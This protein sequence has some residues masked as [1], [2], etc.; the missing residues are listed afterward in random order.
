M[1]I[2]GTLLLGP[3]EHNADRCFNSFKLLGCDLVLV[4]VDFLDEKTTEI[5]NRA[6][7][8]LNIEVIHDKW[9]Y[10]FGRSRNVLQSK[11]PPGF[12]W[13]IWLDS[14]DEVTEADAAVFIESFSKY[15][16][17][18][19]LLMANYVYVD[20][21]GK[22]TY[23]LYRERAFSPYG[24]FWKLHAHEYPAMPYRRAIFIPASVIHHW[25]G[26]EPGRELRYI[27]GLLK[28]LNDPN[29]VGDRARILYY[30]ARS[31]YG[32]DELKEA[33]KYFIEY[34]NTGGW[35]EERAVA[36]LML[37]EIC[38]HHNDLIGAMKW[39][40]WASV[41]M[42]RARREMMYPL[43]EIY[44][45]LGVPYVCYKFLKKIE[46]TNSENGMLHNLPYLYTSFIYEKLYEYSR[47][48]APKESLKWK[49]QTLGLNFK[50][51][52]PVLFIHCGNNY[53][54]WDINSMNRE[55]ISGRE[56]SMSK[57][58]KIASSAGW[59][60]YL[61]I[62]CPYEKII[63]DVHHVRYEKFHEY[64]RDIE[65]DVIIDNIRHSI[66]D[67]DTYSKLNIAFLHDSD[68]GK[69]L[70][71]WPD[72]MTK[73]RDSKIDF[74]FITCDWIIKNLRELYG[75]FDE[76]RAIKVRH[77]IDLKLFPSEFKPENKVR[78]RF[79]YSS[80]WD[81]GLH[82][83]LWLWEYIIKR[84]PDAE[85]HLFYGSHNMIKDIIYPERKY[86]KEWIE[87][88]HRRVDELPNV[89]DHGKVSQ[90]EL[91][92]WYS[93]SAIW[94]FPTTFGETF[95]VSALEAC[96]GYCAI[97]TTSCSGG[98]VELISDVGSIYQIDR[99][100]PEKSFDMLP[101]IF[102]LLE[103]DSYW[104]ERCKLANTKVQKLDENGIPYYSIESAYGD[105]ISKIENLLI[106]KLRG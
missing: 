37:G 86:K 22:A 58:A 85:L 46:S 68:W 99:E 12:D 73:E 9:D 88:I 23:N 51:R 93:S 34:L 18:E 102:R 78:K 35:D 2:V 36:C 69:S 16:P 8:N 96:A 13:Q 75:E 89:F 67:Q 71:E 64:C 11:I 33:Y 38:K 4:L 30:L 50:K 31:Y 62:D 57:L 25:Q 24:V 59:D 70:E 48:C 92:H 104:E 49:F 42:G 10:N 77:G 106:G 103:D 40:E 81:R 60:T 6:K 63:E 84:H 72:Y 3:H 83:L 21:N 98:L 79:I 28:D 45:Q 105:M 80:S 17:K 15:D 7:D 76:K 95:C 29:C 19:T 14:D 54:L 82:I 47:I 27:E 61:F 5:L 97:V 66:W 20:S 101:E 65:P 94:L 32:V 52:K 43:F 90:E 53:E 41:E 91:A 39:I 1:K 100:H 44:E 55:G 26:N 56:T 74:Y 87:F